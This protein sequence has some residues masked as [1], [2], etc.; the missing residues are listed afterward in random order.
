MVLERESLM[1]VIK[2]V[3]KSLQKKNIKGDIIL[4]NDTCLSYLEKRHDPI[5]QLEVIYSPKSTIDKMFTRDEY[6][7]LFDRSIKN[8]I[9][10]NEKLRLYTKISNTSVYCQSL[11][12]ILAMKIK[13]GKYSDLEEIEKMARML[14]ISDI[15]QLENLIEEFYIFNEIDEKMIDEVVSRLFN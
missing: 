1:R 10:K 11:D 14:H 8:D 13:R 6:E 5:D 9:S 4:Y 7:R 12:Y 15:K 3:N 2:Q